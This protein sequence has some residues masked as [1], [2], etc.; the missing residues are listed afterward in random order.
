MDWSV[1]FL[2]N[3][4]KEEFLALPSDIRVKIMTGF[5][6]IEAGGLGALSKSSVKHVRGKIWELR[7][8][9][10]DGIARILYVTV[11]GHRVVALYAFMKKTRKTPKSAIAL[12]ET[13]AKE[14]KK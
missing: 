2:N 11:S 3:R 1:E 14:L 7:F 5:G 6:R 8:T 12:A 13:R 10:K 4:V 9:G